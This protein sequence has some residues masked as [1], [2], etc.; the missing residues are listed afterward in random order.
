M[1]YRK[2]MER[3][4]Y[5]PTRGLRHFAATPA[6]HLSF[7]NQWEA[8]LENAIAQAERLRAEGYMVEEGIQ[9]GA[10]TQSQAE[11]EAKRLSMQGYEIQTIPVTEW[12][13]EKIVF[14]VYKP[15]KEPVAPPKPKMEAQRIGTVEELVQRFTNVWYKDRQE[16]IPDETFKL[17]TEG[18]MIDP[19]RCVALIPRTS[20][21][22]SPT[23]L[24]G[25]A[26]GYR[27]ELPITVI[28]NTPKFR[29]ALARLQKKYENITF[30][31]QGKHAVQIKY[32]KEAL[33]TFEGY[34]RIKVHG[35]P[36]KPI[37]LINE[38]GDAI[39][40][41]PV[42]EPNPSLTTTVSQ[43]EREAQTVGTGK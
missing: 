19:S 38:A 13:G 24:V 27:K 3:R 7:R 40:I 34:R 2:V 17:K 23:D 37:Y 32:L 1:T 11:R 35:Q 31:P 16:L 5:M 39:A 15:P 20:V 30:D 25:M 22:K 4:S 28:E 6:H 10:L 9:R 43:A 14:L 33:R 12:A 18:H 42:I 41:A 21:G 36:E 26:E 29:V 8:N